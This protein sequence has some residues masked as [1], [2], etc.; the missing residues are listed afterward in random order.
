MLKGG[1]RIATA[2]GVMLADPNG[3]GNLPP[4]TEEA[5]FDPN[6]WDSRGELAAVSG[7]RGAAWYV[8]STA[9]PLVLRHYRRGGFIARISQD[10]Y[11]WSGEDRVRAFAEWRLLFYLAQRGLNVPKPVAAFYRRAGLTYRCDLITQRIAHADALSAAL[12]SAALAEP[13]WRAIGVAISRLHSHGV[14]HADLNAHNIL[15]TKN[16]AISVIDFDRGRLRA[17]GPW[18]SNNLSRLQR[19]LTKIAASLPPDRY[20]PESWQHLMAGY[21]KV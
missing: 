2:T 14:D 1:Q 13:V 16:A 11:V 17:P 18:I 15:L 3:L 5:L 9:H 10:R 21:R 12:A 6:F 4:R 20:T 19:S 7:G 8:G